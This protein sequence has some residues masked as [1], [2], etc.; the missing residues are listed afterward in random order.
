MLRQARH[1][2]PIFVSHDAIAPFSILCR[3]QEFHVL[4]LQR[5]LIKKPSFSAASRMSSG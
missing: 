4:L 1:Q 5:S 2:Y 3:R